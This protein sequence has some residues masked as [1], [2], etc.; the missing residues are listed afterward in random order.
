MDT[1]NGQP[2]V[3]VVLIDGVGSEEKESGAS[4]NPLSVNYCPIDPNGTDR[5]TNHGWPAGL[6][7]GLRRWSELPV[8]GGVSGFGAPGVGGVCSEYYKDPQLPTGRDGALNPVDPTKNYCLVA[9][10]ADAGAVLLP[11]S[12]TSAMM[13]GDTSHPQFVF[14][15]YNADDTK[16]DISTSIQKL[17][18]EVFSIHQVWPN[19]HI[20]VV[21]HSLGGL[22]AEQWWRCMVG[23]CGVTF[24]HSNPGDNRNV[25]HVFSLDSPINGVKVTTCDGH[26]VVF[27]AMVAAFGTSVASMFCVLWL[28]QSALDKQ[29]LALESTGN[30]PYTPIGLPDDP[31]YQD[32]PVLGNIGGIQ[33]QV[34]FH[35]QCDPTTVQCTAQPPS[36]VLGPPNAPDCSGTGDLFGVTGHDTVKACPEAIHLILKA[37]MTAKT[38]GPAA[39]A[40]PAP[41]APTWG[42][43]FRPGLT[44]NIGLPENH[45][46]SRLHDAN[47]DAIT[48]D[49]TNQTYTLGQGNGSD[50]ASLDV[51]VYGG[52]ISSQD[53]SDENALAL[54][55]GKVLAVQA[56]CNAVL[57]DYGSGW[58]GIYLHLDSS[59]IWVA[60]G[61]TVAAGTPIGVPTVNVSGCGQ[62]TS[63][64]HVHFAFLHNG[65][66]V[67]MRGMQ[68]CGHAVTDDGLEGVQTVA[69]TP[70]QPTPAPFSQNIIFKVPSNCPAQR[71]ETNMIS[72]TTSA[73]YRVLTGGVTG[74]RAQWV[75]PTISGASGTAMNVAINVGTWQ[76][77]VQNH[78]D[79][80]MGI[81]TFGTVQSDGTVQ[82]QTTADLGSSTETLDVPLA[83]GDTISASIIYTGGS[84]NNWTYTLANLTQG[85][86]GTL[87]VTVT[88]DET[89]PT[90]DIGGISGA[91]LANFTPVQYEHPQVQL[92]SGG[93]VDLAALPYQATQFV[94]NSQTVATAGPVGTSGFTVRRINPSA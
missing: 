13:A 47:Y 17:D 10:L 38:S 31:T 94:E 81:F 39:T 33:S 77:D 73:G 64:Q 40:T 65:Q 4:F 15:A 68:L 8:P 3:V 66:Y 51:G 62:N 45:P 18:D 72:T 25:G 34:L 60:A 35:D 85:R 54:A 2:K 58:W 91:S 76:G 6:S 92:A 5:D 44:V 90:F 88:G 27:T 37:V 49:T 11:Y 93:W 53:V 50:Y 43:P 26:D 69:P 84:S 82:Y 78:P 20:V 46:N 19:T 36:Y 30:L 86:Q 42:F 55:P 80:E 56:S 14:Q 75:M 52:S 59:R 32:A 12:Y 28:G 89:L 1:T 48:D 29:S 67:S 24:N 16:Q 61:D 7:L 41:S 21:G 9:Q 57:I 79:A 23:Q 74:I 22:V 83:A 71:P 70:P 63:F 87:S